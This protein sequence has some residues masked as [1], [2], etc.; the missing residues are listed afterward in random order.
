MAQSKDYPTIK[1]LR[2]KILVP[3]N[4]TTFETEDGTFYSYDELWIDDSGHDVST[5]EGCK[6]VLLGIA[7][8]KKKQ[9]LDGG[10]ELNGTLFD[11]D[12][13][14]R[15]AYA[16]LGMKFQASPTYSTQW[17]ASPGVWVTMDATLYAQIASAGEAHISGIF[18]WLAGV[19][20]QIAAAETV[21]ELMEIEI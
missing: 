14:A 10:F 6:L 18:A 12:I 9:L 8:S 4:I 5:L 15:M 20:A 3:Q 2:G 1:R 19:Q 21:Q 11:S 13:N 16:E 7:G 17:K